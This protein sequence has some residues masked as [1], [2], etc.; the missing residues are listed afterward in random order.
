MAKINDIWLRN[1]IIRYVII[2]KLI[3]NLIIHKTRKTNVNMKAFH[4]TLLATISIKNN[5]DE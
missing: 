1:V 2:T 3:I 4:K 5:P